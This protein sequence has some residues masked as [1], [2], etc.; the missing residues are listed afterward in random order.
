MAE[1]NFIETLVNAASSTIQ[2]IKKRAEEGMA[3]TKDDLA[4]L[5]ENLK[6]ASCA[7]RGTL[8]A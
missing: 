2:Y 8:K 6:E 3:V 7:A 4:V 1:L 5:Q